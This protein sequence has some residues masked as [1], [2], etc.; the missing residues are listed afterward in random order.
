MSIFNNLLEENK[1]K[2]EIEEG[3]VEYK[4]RLDLKT[5]QLI[6]KLTS[7]MLWRLNEGKNNNLMYDFQKKNIN[8]CEAHYIIGVYDDGKFGNIN[9]NELEVSKNIFKEIIETINGYI[10]LEENYIFNDSH[11][12]Y[13]IIRI[14]P[15]DITLKEYNVLV[16]GPEG[17]GKTT[18]ISNLC[19][20]H[21]DNGNGLTRKFILKHSHE[22][23]SG[24]TTSIT[25]E[26]IGIYNNNILNYNYTHNWEE[27]AT[28]SEYIINIYDTP[29][30]MKYFKNIIYSLRTYQI[31]LILIVCTDIQDDYVKFLIKYC[32]T[33]NIKYKLI[34]NK[35]DITDN[36]Y[37]ESDDYKQDNII[38]T[39]Q[40]TMENMNQII[41]ILINLP[42]EIFNKYNYLIK[43]MC[44][45]TDVYTIPDRDIVVG[46]KQ[47][48][49]II[50]R[51]NIYKLI[52]NLNDE[53]NYSFI[54]INSIFKK[55]I[56]SQEIKENESGSISFNIL[57]D[58]FLK[59]QKT[60]II[61]P[62]NYNIKYITDNIK[63]KI[64]YSNKI[65]LD[66]YYVI[67]GNN[68]I[69][70]KIINYDY[71]YLVFKPNNITYLQ[72][73]I[74]IMLLFNNNALLENVIIGKVDDI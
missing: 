51:H 38:N 14:K 9:K 46:G 54:K 37:D 60:M 32:N 13:Y 39:S 66:T 62:E 23:I 44:R 19:F 59:I 50:K 73:D 33:L 26:I 45:I 36:K 52:Y 25:K 56:D 41:N 69:M 8:I 10:H 61:V 29:G 12:V 28:L 48:N 35:L 27:I 2:P 22:K 67:N 55:N 58:K 40:I 6:K 43:N 72:D 30:N 5:P 16:C 63:I 57:E 53:I 74:F 3:N 17:V 64:L 15:K 1:L 7:Q 4:L 24:N 20:S 65:H 71:D 49:G 70:G 18:L 68:K 47:I 34:K 42:T 21:K 31:D 11:I